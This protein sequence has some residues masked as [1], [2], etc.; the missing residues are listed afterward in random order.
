[1]IGYLIGAALLFS[2]TTLPNILYNFGTKLE[3]FGT[4]YTEE[5]KRPNIDRIELN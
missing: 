3:T 4:S 2:A 1:M 5:D